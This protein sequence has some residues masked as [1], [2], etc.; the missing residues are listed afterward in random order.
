M[1]TGMIADQYII[2]D[3]QMGAQLLIQEG[4]RIEFFE[5]DGTNVRENKITVRIEE[6]IAF[7]VYGSTFFVVGSAGS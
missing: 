1:S 4:M 6:T 7:P 3:W 5:Q 2:G